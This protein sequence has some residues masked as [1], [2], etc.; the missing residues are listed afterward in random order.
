[1]CKDQEHEG[2]GLLLSPVSY[3][4]LYCGPT[5]FVM[6]IITNL[7]N[8]TQQVALNANLGVLTNHVLIQQSAED[9][10][11]GRMRFSVRRARK[12]G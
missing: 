9:R 5:S 6:K 1:M 2:E 4:F 10:A 8:E 3:L 12:S 11:A 7:F